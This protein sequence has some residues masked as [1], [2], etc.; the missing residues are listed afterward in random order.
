MP[1]E[2]LAA[3]LR[4]ADMD[5]VSKVFGINPPKVAASK[6]VGHKCA[7]PS[8]VL[9]VELE[10]ERCPQRQDWYQNELRAAIWT[11]DTD[12]SLRPPGSSFEF[13]SKPLESAHMLAELQSFFDKTKFGNESY[14]D[15]TSVHLH[16]NVTDF[17]QSQLANLAL[18][19]TIVEDT[20][21]DFVNYYKAPTP[22][23]YSRDTNLYCIPW[24]QCRMNFGLVNNIFAQG[25]NAFRN[26]QK[27]TALNLIPVVE[28]GTVEFRHMHGTNDMEKLT[29]WINMIGCIMGFAKKHDFDDVVRTVKTLNDTSAYQQFFQAVFGD[30]VSYQDTHHRTLAEGVINAKYALINWEKNKGK[31]AA[32]PETVEAIQADAVARLEARLRL[33]REARRLRVPP[34]QRWDAAIAPIRQ[35]QGGIAGDVVAGAADAP[36]PLRWAVMDRALDDIFEEGEHE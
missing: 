34:A 3:L 2:R 31:K 11:V 15:R 12:G 30:Y 1:A 7:N 10:I 35:E 20:F 33:D 23:G 9:G 27:Y 17:T 22:E 21:F 26:W 8:L 4:L 13:I 14:S 18:V 32:P 36:R 6:L 29:K 5:T 24:N 25:G 28:Q 19:Y 16:A